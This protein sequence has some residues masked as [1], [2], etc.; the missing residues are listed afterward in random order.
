MTA[1]AI[2]PAVAP[3]LITAAELETGSPWPDDL[4]TWYRLAD[5]TE[6]TPAGYVLPFYRPLP[7]AEIVTHWRMWQDIARSVGRRRMV[8]EAQAQEA[9]AC[10]GVFLPA[11]LPIAEDQ[12]GADRFV[13]RRSGASHGCVGEFLK[14]DADAD[15]PT[16]PSVTAM[17]SDVADA[18]EQDRPSAGW[19][20]QVCGSELDWRP[21]GPHPAHPGPAG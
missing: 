14:G 15:G 5:G 10:A 6:R 9:G 3:A 17:L 1:A 8:E 18:L 4:R 16:W 12:S 2:R 11:F 19:Q 13:D 7:V 21:A 20:P